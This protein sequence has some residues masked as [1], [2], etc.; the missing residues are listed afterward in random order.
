MHQ[1]LRVRSGEVRRVS[2]YDPLDLFAGCDDSRESTI[3]ESTTRRVRA[4]R[5]L[6]DAPRNNLRVARRGFSWPG[7]R[8]TTRLDSDSGESSES[9]D[10]FV[11]RTDGPAT[12]QEAKR[13]GG[14]A[15]LLDLVNDA[16]AASGVLAALLRAQR[17]DTIGAETA[18]A[19]YES[20]SSTS[21]DVV[22]DDLEKMRDFVVAAVAKDC[23]VLVAFREC[24][25][26]DDDDAFDDDGTF[27]V[28]AAAEGGTLPRV[29]YRCRVSVVDVDLKP[30]ANISKWLA[31]H[32]RI[33]R[34]WATEKRAARSDAQPPSDDDSM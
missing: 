18:A 30:I 31:T 16:L 26:D 24:E 23:S 2:A 8:D 34:N 7:F 5:A 3:R 21:S 28:A 29:R 4:L 13:L 15:R 32:R 19:L 22:S 17:R 6:A 11:S 1:A 12:G 27:A 10:A 14:A 33:A 9:L 20:L 25:R